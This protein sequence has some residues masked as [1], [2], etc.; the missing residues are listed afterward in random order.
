MQ[1]FQGRMIEKL[2]INLIPRDL[3]LQLGTEVEPVL[4][5]GGTMHIC[6]WGL[7]FFL[8]KAHVK[9]CLQLY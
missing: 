5:F 7:N 6:M 9:I 4:I 8:L 1:R 2:R 3:K